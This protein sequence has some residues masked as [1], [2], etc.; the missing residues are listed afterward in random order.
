MSDDQ[1]EPMACTAD[2]RYAH[3]PGKP[4]I[5]RTVITYQKHDIREILTEKRQ[6]RR[7]RRHV[8]FGVEAVICAVD[9]WGHIKQRAVVGTVPVVAR[10]HRKIV[11][12]SVCPSV[13]NR[14]RGS[15]PML[16]STA[17]VTFSMSS[18]MVSSHTGG[19]LVYLT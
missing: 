2:K 14:S 19:K 5:Y 7:Q 4:F 3:Q 6:K 17:L 13:Q 9:D 12:A 16:R 11:L 15:W 10:V 1:I 8:A 18:V